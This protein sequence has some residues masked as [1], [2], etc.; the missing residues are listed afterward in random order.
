MSNSN[1]DRVPLLHSHIKWKFK[2]NWVRKKLEEK[3]TLMFAIVQFNNKNLWSLFCIC[4]PLHV[5][6]KHKL[7]AEMAI[8][9]IVTTTQ[10]PIRTSLILASDNITAKSKVAYLSELGR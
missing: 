2:P 3:K 8:F 5:V 6:A 9:S 1:K 4:L 10:P 7:E